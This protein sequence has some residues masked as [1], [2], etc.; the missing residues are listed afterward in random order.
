[1]QYQSNVNNF[2]CNI[3]KSQSNLAKLESQTIRIHLHLSKG[4]E[5]IN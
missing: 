5:S 3:T 1:M 2:D 4:I